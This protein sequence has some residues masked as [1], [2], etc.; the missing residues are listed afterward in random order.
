LVDLEKNTKQHISI[1]R[2]GQ[3]LRSMGLERKSKRLNG[4]IVKGYNLKYTYE[5]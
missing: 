5:D 1:K 2:I 3:A 4:K